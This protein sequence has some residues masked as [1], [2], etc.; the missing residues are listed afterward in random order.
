[1]RLYYKGLVL[2][3]YKTFA[4]QGVSGRME[5]LTAVLLPPEDDAGF[6]ISDA[7]L[8]PKKNV[9]DVLALYHHFLA[10]GRL[11]ERQALKILKTA[12]VLLA[13]EPRLLELE[14]PMT[15]VADI[16]GQFFDLPQLFEA[17][18]DPVLDGRKYLFLGD[19]VD[20][21]KFSCEVVLF[22][23]ALKICRPADVHLL[24][25][26]HET[27]AQ[28]AK[29]GTM[30]ECHVKY[31][32]D[33]YEELMDVFDHLP[34]AATVKTANHKLFCV[35]GGISPRILDVHDINDIPIEVGSEPSGAAKDLL[36]ADPSPDMARDPEDRVKL[37]VKNAEKIARYDAVRVGATWN[38]AKVKAIGAAVE[39]H[40]REAG[41][42]R[43]QVVSCLS[44]ISPAMVADLE[45]STAGT[46]SAAAS[47]AATKAKRRPAKKR[48]MTSR[49]GPDPIKTLKIH[50]KQ[51]PPQCWDLKSL[52]PQDDEK[53]MKFKAKSLSDYAKLFKSS[54]RGKTLKTYSYKA[55]LAFMQANPDILCIVRGHEQ[56]KGYELYRDGPRY[57]FPMA[58]TIFSAPNYVD[59]SKN[60][61]SVMTVDNGVMELRPY[62]WQQHPQM[63]SKKGPD[64]YVHDLTRE[65]FH[66]YV[67]HVDP[68][69]LHSLTEKEI[70]HAYKKE[71]EVA[72]P[73]KV[74]R[75]KGKKVDHWAAIAHNLGKAIAGV[76]SSEAPKAKKKKNKQLLAYFEGMDHFK[77]AENQ[78]E[79]FEMCWDE[80]EHEA[81]SGAAAS[82]ASAS[83]AADG[84]FDLASY[85]YWNA[86][87]VDLSDS[88]DLESECSWDSASEA[89][90]LNDF[91]DE[92]E[93]AEDVVKALA[94]ASVTAE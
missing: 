33:F 15:V 41:E 60:L 36:W 59:T 92:D 18:G 10:E 29:C 48:V 34:Y 49:V 76:D 85:L 38:A 35:H 56:K 40:M 16:H 53:A 71:F 93:T 82:A 14:E 9:L 81:S 77:K 28:T 1:M 32:E 54:V 11:S 3:P 64:G 73:A 74:K 66:Q 46:G 23:L 25:A 7:V 2:D 58:M 20:R 8:F 6:L 39:Q 89:G 43:D 79:E 21:G 84:G 63:S 75:A 22:V 87:D 80:E 94:A 67:S 65:D 70:E 17:G 90:D 24:R 69:A 13:D 88:D 86:S 42:A 30:F 44:K 50:Q 72:R 26:N 62:T 52:L 78:E 27:R 61:A 37:E 45:R 12:K 51:P 47:S 19:Y 91:A 83:S 68:V 4:A 55:T 57:K 5:Q 31:S